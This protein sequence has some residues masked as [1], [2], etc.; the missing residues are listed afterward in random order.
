M[1][2]AWGTNERQTRKV[3]DIRSHRAPEKTMGSFLSL[4]ISH[5]QEVGSILPHSASHSLS[6]VFPYNEQLIIAI[7][8]HHQQLLLLVHI[9]LLLMIKSTERAVRLKA[10]Q[11]RS[12]IRGRPALGTVYVGLFSS[13]QFMSYYTKLFLTSE[14]FS[15]RVCDRYANCLICLLIKGK[16]FQYTGTLFKILLWKSV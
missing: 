13:R 1:Q 9:L 15:M 12:L 14:S 6:S 5:L 10:K 7:C 4:S 2:L 11:G 16:H 3:M 8:G